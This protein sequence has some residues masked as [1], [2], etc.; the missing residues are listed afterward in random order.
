M[1]L[2]DKFVLISACWIHCSQFSLH[3]LFHAKLHHLN[4][5][6]CLLNLS[7]GTICF[8]HFD[9]KLKMVLFRQMAHEA[10]VTLLSL[11]VALV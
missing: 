1:I 10:A 2:K 4:R 7:Q 11:K 8:V 3:W 6:Q 5:N 9:F